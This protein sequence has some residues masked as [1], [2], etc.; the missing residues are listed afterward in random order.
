MSETADQLLQALDMRA[1]LDEDTAERVGGIILDT[2]GGENR[3][4]PSFESALHQWLRETES[5]ER[6][7]AAESRKAA[8]PNTFGHGMRIGSLETISELRDWLRDEWDSS[9]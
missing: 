4:D 7:M 8:G 1:D 3:V 9:A 2:L 5:R 6:E